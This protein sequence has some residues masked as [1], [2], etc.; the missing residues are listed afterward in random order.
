RAMKRA[1]GVDLGGSH[2]TAGIVTEDGTIET[3]HELDITDTSFENV[4]K[5]TSSV[6]SLAIAD[7]SKD[8]SAVPLGVGAAG[9]VDPESGVV[10]YSPNLKWVDAPLG[11]RLR[12]EFKQPVFIGNDARCA[13]LGEYHFG[14]GKGTRNFV[15]LTLGTGLGGGIV[16]E[17]KLLLGNRFGA[18]EVGHQQIRPT[19]GFICTCGKIG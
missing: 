19:D 12:N 6:N 4:V 14:I 5:A 13:T 18:G 17:G 11:Q 2:V 9:N 15:L 10:L 8:S 1:I 16:G 7:I 3:Q